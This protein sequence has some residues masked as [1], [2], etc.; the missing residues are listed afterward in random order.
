M[1]YRGRLNGGLRLRWGRYFVKA[2][3]SAPILKVKTKKR[4]RLADKNSKSSLTGVGKAV[5]TQRAGFS[6]PYRPLPL[7]IEGLGKKDIADRLQCLKAKIWRK[8]V[9]EAQL[10]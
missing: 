4:F 10:W 6:K 1:E 8:S 3:L 2:F 9:G 5:I 7:E